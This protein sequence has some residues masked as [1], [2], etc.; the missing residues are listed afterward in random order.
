MSWSMDYLRDYAK[1]HPKS[2]VEYLVRRIDALERARRCTRD[3]Q[4]NAFS[5]RY[6]RRKAESYSQE[7]RNYRRGRREKRG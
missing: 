5:A 7:L 1:A 6:W 3:C 2:A 4:Q